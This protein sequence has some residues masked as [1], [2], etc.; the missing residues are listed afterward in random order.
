MVLLDWFN[1]IVMFLKDIGW[2]VQDQASG[3]YYVT[4]VGKLKSNIV[5]SM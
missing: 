4:E 2:V 3:L 1:G 5:V